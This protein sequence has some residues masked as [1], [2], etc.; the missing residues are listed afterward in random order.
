MHSLFILGSRMQILI[1]DK[2]HFL[3]HIGRI[4]ESP[5]EQS[6]TQM[7]SICSSCIPSAKIEFRHR[8][9]NGEALY[10]GIIKETFI[11]TLIIHYR[12]LLPFQMIS[13]NYDGQ[14]SYHIFPQYSLRLAAMCN[15]NSYSN[16]H[17]TYHQSSWCS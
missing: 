10:T 9:I 16:S 4:R 11:F 2:I 12:L 1:M 7:I 8:S 13:C 14:T 5:F 3:N 17:Y 15:Q 6:S